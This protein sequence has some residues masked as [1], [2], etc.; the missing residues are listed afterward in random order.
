[1]SLWNH[2]HL[3]Q[4]VED[5]LQA[6]A[7]CVGTGRV[8]AG[9]TDLLLDLQQ[10]RH[11][12]VDLLVDVNQIAEMTAV[13]LESGCV[14]IG[15]ATP[16]TQLVENTIIQSHAQALI[17]ACGLIGGP[18]VRN[19]ATLG[20]NVAHALP[21]GDGSIA[22][23]ALGAKAEV[24]TLG[25]RRVLPLAELFL[26]PGK[27]SLQPKGEILVRFLLPVL[28]KGQASAFRRVMRPQGVAL[29]VLNMAVWLEKA[30]DGTGEII[31][32]IRIAIGPTG[33]VP[34]RAFATEAVLRGKSVKGEVLEE[35]KATLRN[36]ARFRSSP[37]RATAEYRRHLAGVLLEQTIEAAWERASGGEQHRMF[38]QIVEE[39]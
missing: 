7:A 11:I 39:V 17:E 12:P 31:Q 20:G 9:G 32:D 6:L 8:I 34:F 37:Q 38:Y 15:A 10:G 35:A 13:E 29:P 16:L 27:T 1:M 30:A 19:S 4:S 2:Y 5:A 18:Q 24:A 14:S 36:E 25:G 3:A 26:G 28:Q 22:L 21:A 23:L 33:P